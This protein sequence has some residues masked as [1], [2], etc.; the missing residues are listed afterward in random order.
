MLNTQSSSRLLF[1]PGSSRMTTSPPRPVFIIG[2]PRS[3]T[4][5]MT[6]AL[7]QHPDIQPMPETA[8]IAAEAVASLQSFRL[9]SE[10]GGL[11]PL[12]H[13]RLPFDAFLEHKG[14]TIDAKI[15]DVLARRLKDNYGADDHPVVAQLAAPEALNG[16]AV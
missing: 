11:P 6:W 4:S 15:H 14:L 16:E 13:V 8:W 2:A 7:G 10:R 5:V 1:A 12:S 9:G 3:G